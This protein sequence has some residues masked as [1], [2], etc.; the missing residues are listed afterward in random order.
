MPDNEL[1]MVPQS[2]QIEEGMATLDVTFDGEQGTIEGG[3]PF[4]LSDSEIKTIATECLSSGSIQGI[5][6]K[7]GANL[8]DF[9]V[10]R[11]NSKDGLPNRLILRPKTP[12]GSS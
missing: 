9:R 4:D 11:F 12:F 1:I 5:G 8:A 6:Q 3:I 10:D 7:P 2:P